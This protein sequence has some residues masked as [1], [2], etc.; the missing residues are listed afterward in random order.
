M[1]IALIRGAFLNQYE[2]QLYYPLLDRHEIVAFCSNK[3]IHDSH[4]FNVQKLMSPMDI[5]FGRFSRFKMPILNRL[6]VDAH[7]LIGLEN[8][9]QGFDIAHC[10]DTFYHFTHQSV[11]AKK[12]GKVKKV[13][14]TIFENIPFNNEGIR[15]RK[16]YKRDAIKNIDHFIAISERSKASLILEGANEDII[17]VIGQRIDT[18]RFHP[19]EKQ[20]LSKN[21]TILFS[22]R[23][24]FYKGIYEVIY[25]AKRLINDKNLSNYSLNFIL[26]GDGSQKTQLI[27]LIKLLNIRN[28]VT[29]KSV[30]YSEM[31][32]VYQ[33]ADIFLAP[34]RAT[35]TY[36]EQFSTVLLEAQA[37]GLPIVTTY[38]GGIPENVENAAIMANP[39]DFYSISEALK[40]FILDHKLRKYY[41]NKAKDHVKKYSVEVGSKEIEKIYEQVLK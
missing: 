10:A 23:L 9:L 41:G 12:Q 13:V 15:G 7:W 26:V 5:E 20:N 18:E 2:S 1:R 28:Q 40:K 22:G 21:I 34:S 29:I 33:H 4:F 27:N 24:E 8:K 39:G 25:A 35:L 6:F 3:P 16:Q 30:P 17:T 19:A 11:T 38:S 31:P 32:N 36:Q 14:A 37:S